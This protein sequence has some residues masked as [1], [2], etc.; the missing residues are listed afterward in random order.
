[1]LS[2]SKLS[3]ASATVGYYM[4]GE[5]Y[6]AV[7]ELGG[8]LAAGE[9]AGKEGQEQG[10]EQDARARI[11]GYYLAESQ[12]EPVTRAWAGKGAK[13]LGLGKEVDVQDFTNLLEGKLPSGQ[14]LGR[15][16]DGELKHTPGTDLTFSAPKSV[17][18]AVHVLGREDILRAHERAVHKALAYIEE[19]VLQTRV[20]NRATRKRDLRGNQEMV[21]V[22][23]TEHTSRNLDP[24]I[25]THCIVMNACCDRKD[26]KWRSIENNP[27]YEHSKMLGTVY[28]SFLASD[29]TRLGYAIDRTN[30]DGTFELAGVSEEAIKA[31]ST[32]RAEIVAEMKKSGFTN[33]SS[34]QVATLKTRAKKADTISWEEKKTIWQSLGERIGLESLSHHRQPHKDEDRFAAAD[35]AVQDALASITERLATFGEKELRQNALAFAMGKADVHAID[36]AIAHARHQQ[37]IIGPPASGELTTP[38]MVKL[39][40]D[41]ITL[42][43]NAQDKRTPIAARD[44]VE[45]ALTGTNLNAGQAAAARTVLSSNDAIVG[46]QGS[47]GTGKTTMLSFVRDQLDANGYRMIGLAPS[48]SA[49]HVLAEET[50]SETKTLQRF[51]AEMS[52]VLD[53]KTRYLSE[54]TQ[55][56]IARAQDTVIVV[57]E[58]SL[59]S[60]RQMNKLMNICQAVGV[61]QVALIGDKKQLDAVEAGT[62]FAQLQSA[63]MQT[64]EMTEIMRQ[65]DTDLRDAVNYSI[66]GDIAN[67]FE[68]IGER[69]IQVGEHGLGDEVASRWFLLDDSTRKGTLIVAPT[70]SQRQQINGAIRDRLIDD[71]AINAEQSVAIESAV[72]TSFST[73]EKSKASSYATGVDLIFSRDLKKMGV[74]AGETWRVA[75]IDSEQNKIAVTRMGGNAESEMKVL[76]LEKFR[77]NYSTAFEVFTPATI[78]LAG[79]DRIRFTRNDKDAGLRNNDYGRVVDVSNGQVHFQLDDGKRVSLDQQDA[80][81]RHIDYAWASTVHSSQGKTVDHIFAVLDSRSRHMTNQKTFYVEISR[82]RHS[83]TLFTDDRQALANRLSLATGEKSTALDLVTAPQHKTVKHHVPSPGRVS[84]RPPPQTPHAERSR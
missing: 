60:S 54:T 18:L 80:R 2:I 68:K 67:A 45:E 11:A 21:A 83:A 19:N 49:A 79:G 31:F 77:G 27:L 16:V 52:G 61:A 74:A 41:N 15:M 34:A 3:S 69:V 36:N 7:M 62:P 20:F 42:L 24:Q 30:R 26:G 12:Q 5:V 8:E 35:R 38:E 57:D 71:G 66:K 75:S 73:Q 56:F 46:I 84:A 72:G 47:A 55:D 43:E 25:H 32:R 14:Q 76:D 82:A 51:L 70:N 78:D 4:S 6:K 44:T 40:H 58:A 53:G 63:G 22:T 59:I 39:E 64:A 17:S 33:A 81:L 28:Q 65:R 9:N 1:M 10:Q 50:Q 37:L 23:K 29:L 48:A 13:R